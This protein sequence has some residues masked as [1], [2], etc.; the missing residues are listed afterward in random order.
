MLSLGEKRWFDYFPWPRAAYVLPCSQLEKTTGKLS[1][2]LSLIEISLSNVSLQIGVRD[3]VKGL[4][5]VVI[6]TLK[7]VG[8]EGFTTANTGVWVNHPLKGE[9]KICSI[10]QY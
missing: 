9:S 8:V 7:E 1:L 2:S 6:K 4:E 3:Y 5:K 10:G